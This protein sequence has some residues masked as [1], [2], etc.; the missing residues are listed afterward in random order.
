[1][2]E[3]G[4]GSLFGQQ[5]NAQATGAFGSQPQAPAS[6]SFGFGSK[7]AQS[8][9]SSSPSAP[10]PFGFSGAAQNPSPFGQHN[11][12][13]NTGTGSGLFGSSGAASGQSDS[14][15]GLFGNTA[16]PAP[17]AG[18]GG[19]FGNSTNTGSNTGPNTGS[20]GLF[21]NAANNNNKAPGGFSF[22]NSNNTAATGANFGF[23]APSAKPLFGSAAAPSNNASAPSSGFGINS[24][25]NA[26]GS[27]LFGNTVS[28]T[29]PGNTLGG[30]TLGGSTLGNSGGLFGKPPTASLFGQ[31]QQVP[32]QQL[33]T[34]VDQ[35]SYVLSGVS[36]SQKLY[37]SLSV[38]HSK[39]DHAESESLNYE[40]KVPV[41]RSKVALPNHR[42]SFARASHQ[43][44]LPGSSGAP[45]SG[46]LKTNS[47]II[48][49][50]NL[51]TTTTSQGEPRKWI[52]SYEKFVRERP[53]T[54]TIKS[55][56]RTPVPTLLT[57]PESAPV[58]AEPPAIASSLPGN[59][60]VSL[61][62]TLEKSFRDDQDDGISNEPDV[63]MFH[64]QANNMTLVRV[65]RQAI[66]EGYYI[67]P[68][69]EDL[70]AMSKQQLLHVEHLVVGREGFGKIEYPGAVNLSRI[71]NLGDILGVLVVF[72][73]GTV[74]VYPNEGSK[75]A[76][77]NE[78]NMPCVVSIENAW[79]RDSST[80]KII[81]DVDDPRMLKHIQRLRKA[82]ESRGGEF[83]T[84]T[85]GIW[86]FKV[87]HFSTWG[88]P[89]SEMVI[90]DD[91]SEESDSFSQALNPEPRLASSSEDLEDEEM[92]DNEA[93]PQV[94]Y[95]PITVKDVAEQFDEQ[96]TDANFEMNAEEAKEMHDAAMTESDLP[97]TWQD[98]LIHASNGVLLAASG[99]L[100]A[101]SEPTS[102]LDLEDILNPLW[103]KSGRQNMQKAEEVKQFPDTSRSNT[104]NAKTC[105]S[106]LNSL[107]ESIRIT[108]RQN[109]NLPY[110]HTAIQFQ[111]ICNLLD[112]RKS[113]W[114]L[115][116]ILY[117]SSKP[118]EEVDLD[119]L[120]TWL[121]ESVRQLSQ[122][123]E[124][125][126][127]EKIWQL[128]SCHDLHTAYSLAVKSNNIH[129]SLLLSLLDQPTSKKTLKTAAEN[130]LNDW[131]SSYA[132]NNIP[133]SVLRIWEVAAGKVPTSAR[134]DWKQW[135]GLQ[136]WY[137][138]ERSVQHAIQALP[139]TYAAPKDLEL[140]FFEC[141]A[142]KKQLRTAV[143]E[144][145]HI[146]AFF[147]L[148][149]MLTNNPSA[150][151]ADLKCLDNVCT[152]LAEQFDQAGDAVTAVYIGLHISDTKLSAKTIRTILQKSSMNISLPSHFGVPE[153]FL[154]E[155]RANQVAR[156]GEYTAQAEYL[157]RAG[158]YNDAHKVIIS[159]AA[160]EAVLN[161][162]MVQLL[163]V[164]ESLDKVKEKLKRWEFGGNVYLTY[165]RALSQAP[166]QY[167]VVYLCNALR[168]IDTP[169][170]KSE[171]AV[172]QIAKWVASTSVAKS[173]LA[174]KLILNMKFDTSQLRVQ[175]LQ[176]ASRL[177]Q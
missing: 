89:T 70:A 173:T 66:E 63:S 164:L 142:S 39:R 62:P 64:R 105:S 111:D 38:Q 56:D 61:N 135:L 115:L 92:S 1:M 22:G 46:S 146:E 168:Y 127:L 40:S 34:G 84:F 141:F 137:C 29:Q 48:G 160:P 131:S 121:D 159:E 167:T 4:S 36:P 72:G 170:L 129:L 138:E 20:G 108:P 161:G 69:L 155:S 93:A 18:T 122:D 150:V 42:T 109:S 47:A 14:G 119:R 43:K 11:A 57:A 67:S 136:F 151:K 100:V 172:S 76:P 114:K 13:Q 103:K 73:P 120:S 95:S 44:S 132:L 26:S 79:P 88:L 41:A 6:S 128:V 30:S 145:D 2:S 54:L 96:L 31:A 17:N 91:D 59:A 147:C 33:Q 154:N 16:K 140:T 53:T 153:E 10:K 87:P 78:L 148:Q 165:A 97:Q 101:A 37:S 130:Q 7:R 118:P 49:S 106:R 8:F 71:S 3:F 104:F 117:D 134:F 65:N 125:T 45:L 112:T 133:L 169:T 163:D 23:G 175:T 77:G 28:S 124:G 90:G 52:N 123:L 5:T 58:A 94:T 9:D 60:S 113:L 158:L 99:S 176:E 51:V 139:R 68:R 177:L 12:A 80:Q 156:Q 171:K 110:L 55:Q 74:C 81:K 107:R 157:L 24:T 75:S 85:Q 21:G 152:K 32:Q 82:C 143:N 162:N 166:D 174:S 27:G 19:L 35:A 50:D 83:V 98:Q 15:G 149:A 144:L 102:K 86:V 25:N 126:T 116:S